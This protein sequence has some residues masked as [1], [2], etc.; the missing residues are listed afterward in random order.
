[1]AARQII[2]P[3][4][5]PSRDE[6]G[7]A[8]PAYLRFYLPGTT[9]PASVYTS[10]ALTTAHPFP[11]PSDSTGRFAQIW[12]DE[13]ST[14]DVAWSDQTHDAL[15]AG[16]S[17]IQPLD[18]AVLASVGLAESAADAAEAAAAQAQEIADKFGDAD[19]A[20]TAAEAAQVAAE[21]ARDAAVA[22]QSGSEDAVAAAL[23]A[24][25]AAEAARDQAIEVV[26]FDPTNVVRVD[27]AQGFD[28][29][30]KALARANIDAQ[31]KLA[32]RIREKVLRPAIAAGVLTLDASEA[33]GA[34]IHEVSW[35]TNVTSLVITGVVDDADA[36]T[37]TL[38]LLA[39]GGSSYAPGSAYKPFGT[40]APTLSTTAGDRNMLT[41]T[42]RDGGETWDQAYAGYTRP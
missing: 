11:L 40:V 6:N 5:M 27:V 34:S 16:Y 24:Q 21:E 28:A 19:G 17:D 8:L 38:I 41:L 12:A 9:T 3:G 30:E 1:M 7:R 18:D 22:A 25:A 32:V 14:F 23:A 10:D 13:V 37:L 35:A 29:G 20:A 42:T 4:A 36:T 33:T 39:A 31:P 2:V 15:I 26:G